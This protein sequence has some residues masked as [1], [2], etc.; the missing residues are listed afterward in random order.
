MALPSTKLEEITDIYSHPVAL[1]Q[2]REWLEENL[3]SIDQHAYFDTAMSAIKVSK[4]KSKIAAIGSKELADDL[5]LNIIASDIGSEANYTRFVSFSKSKNVPNNANKTS[6]IMSTSHAEGALYEAL[7]CFAK[8]KLNLTKLESHPIQGSTFRYQFYIDLETILDSKQ[9]QS[10][11]GELTKIGAK[12]QVI[13][14]FL[15]DNVI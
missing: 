15:A 8:Q 11:K 14:C 7:G 13:G 4:S 1:N 2:C 6:V 3:G 10:A 9:I 5:G 12:I